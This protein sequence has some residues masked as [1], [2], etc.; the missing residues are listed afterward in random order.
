MMALEISAVLRFEAPG[1]SKERVENEHMKRRKTF[2][3]MS[4][5][6]RG[7]WMRDLDEKPEGIMSGVSL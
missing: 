3:S 7:R 4:F 6:R 2:V 1:R 5:E